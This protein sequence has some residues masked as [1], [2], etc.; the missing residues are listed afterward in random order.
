[1]TAAAAVAAVSICPLCQ[2][3]VGKIKQLEAR[4]DELGRRTCQLETYTTEVSA[5][6]AHYRAW[7]ERQPNEAYAHA[8]RMLDSAIG[9]AR[10]NLWDDGDESSH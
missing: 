5:A 7:L 8:L 1:M 3:P 6:T 2:E 9:K 10:L 4:L